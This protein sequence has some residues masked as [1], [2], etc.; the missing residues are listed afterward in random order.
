MVKA[1][2]QRPLTDREITLLFSNEHLVFEYLFENSNFQMK[3]LR[4]ILRDIKL[5][6]RMECQ[7][8]LKLTLLI[9]LKINL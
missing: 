6:E 9:L 3:N 8:C 2:S 7:R 5:L 1:G 4:K